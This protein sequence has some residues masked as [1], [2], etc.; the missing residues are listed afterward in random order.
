M[1]PLDRMRRTYASPNTRA[2]QPMSAHISFTGCPLIE[3]SFMPMG[4][5]RTPFSM[6]LIAH[7]WFESRISGKIEE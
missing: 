4:V 6:L 1:A 2:R 7:L 3:I 5:N